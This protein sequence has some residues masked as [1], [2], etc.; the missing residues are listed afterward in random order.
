M[1]EENVINWW[2]VF[3]MGLGLTIISFIVFPL[4]NVWASRLSGKAELQHANNQQ[5][6]QISEAQAR[7]D[8]AQLNKQAAIIEAEAV[9]EQIKK[10]G[11][12]LNRHDLYLKWQWIKMMEDADHATIYVPTESNLPI[13]EAARLNK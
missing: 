3:G 8:A 13:L 9:S 10:I 5:K 11:E 7:L 12:N 6:I 1:Y 2:L 4:W